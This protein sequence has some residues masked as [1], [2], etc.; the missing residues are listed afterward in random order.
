MISKKTNFS[1]IFFNHFL[2]RLRELSIIF[3]FSISAAFA[4]PASS[5]EKAG[6]KSFAKGDYFNAAFYFDQALDVKGK[7]VDL[8]YKKAESQRLYNDYKNAAV[9]YSRVVADD[10]DKKYPLAVFYL[11]EMKRNLGLYETAKGFY[12]MYDMRAKN[13]QDYFALKAK[14]EIGGCDTALKILANPV[15]A[16]VSNM[17]SNINSVYSDFAGIM[18]NSKEL[19]FSSNKFEESVPGEKGKKSFFSKILTSEKKNNRYILAAPME[20]TINEAN[21]NNSNATISADKKLMVLCRCKSDSIN[22]LKCK[23][24]ESKFADKVWSIPQLIV[25]SNIN[26]EK[27]TYTQP[28]LATNGNDGYLLYFA[29][30]MAGGY[31]KTD[32]WK[33]IVSIDGKMNEPVNAGNIVNTFADEATPFYSKAEEALYFSSEGHEGLGGFDVF[34]SK[35]NGVGFDYPTNI[36]APLNSGANDLY[37]TVNANDTTGV[38]TSNRMGS[39]FI[40]AATCCYD[41]YYYELPKEEKKKITGEIK[42]GSSIISMDDGPMS[43]RDTATKS[44]IELELDF[45]FPLSLYFDNDQPDPGT[46]NETTKSSYDALH[47][48]Y[49]KNMEKYKKNYLA[50]LGKTDRDSGLKRISGF[51]NEDLNA[52]YKRLDK[53]CDYILKLLERGKTVDL[54]VKGSTSPLADKDYNYH[55]SQRRISCFFNYINNYEG[56]AMKKYLETKNLNI[57]MEAQGE[58][59]FKNVSDE[60]KNQSQSI[61][62]PEAARARRIEV[63]S[64][65]IK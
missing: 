2:F 14:L 39:L 11:A 40:K 52:G 60:A 57:I 10:D 44:M 55:L 21:Q 16:K 36:G 5:F 23:M 27:Y 9:S 63:T 34:R 65:S 1:F 56:G 45:T 53:M 24:Y 17:G 54:T 59:A 58:D 8:S 37:F 28:S 7:D 48:Q 38:L 3:L 62:S 26:I 41:L 33:S 61:Y 13:T 64:L 32:I 20:E 49:M 31:G 51:F 4:Q 47:I 12:K 46:M 30:D 25:A 22:K 18:L 50:G 42:K 6:D 19:Y 29:S 35:F 15:K 43:T